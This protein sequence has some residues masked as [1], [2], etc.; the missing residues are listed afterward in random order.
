[1]FF[2]VGDRFQALS[3]RR[4]PEVCGSRKCLT[5]RE[6]MDWG[7]RQLFTW[8]QPSEKWIRLKHQKL[9]S[10]AAQLISAASYHIHS[11]PI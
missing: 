11:Y 9:S 1:M 4:F 2:S 6:G 7:C 8:S 10:K 3:L 5:K